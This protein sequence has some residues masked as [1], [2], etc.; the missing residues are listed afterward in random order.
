M[1]HTAQRLEV[2]GE[3]DP[4]RKVKGLRVFGGTRPSFPAPLHLEHCVGE[5]K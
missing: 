3:A 4:K 2:E 5:A 1:E